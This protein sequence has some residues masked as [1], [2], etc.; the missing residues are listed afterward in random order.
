MRCDSFLN[1]DRF[2]SCKVQ[3]L[4]WAGFEMEKEHRGGAA[5]LL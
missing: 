2:G 3:V 5:A 4:K 1:T